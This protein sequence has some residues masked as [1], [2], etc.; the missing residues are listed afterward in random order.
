MIDWELIP[1]LSISCFGVPDSPKVSFVATNSW[2]TGLFLTKEKAQAHIDAGAKKVI[3][4]APAKDD[5]KTIVL[6]VNDQILT[7]EEHKL[8]YNIRR[9][10]DSVKEIRIKYL[11]GEINL[12]EIDKN[13]KV[14]LESK[15]IDLLNSKDYKNLHIT[16]EKGN[17]RALIETTKIKL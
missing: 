2:G 8:L 12:L 1:Y 9:N 16:G 7:N 6:G 15:L 3:L 14:N 4:S 13:K 11:H 10:L 5:T 17:I